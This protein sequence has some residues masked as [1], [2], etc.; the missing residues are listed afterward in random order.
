MLWY[1]NDLRGVTVSPKQTLL[2][3]KWISFSDVPTMNPLLCTK[4]N[5]LELASNDGIVH[6]MLETHAYPDMTAIENGLEIL[7]VCLF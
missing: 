5:K 6:L 3:E 2:L 7:K 4:N 1:H